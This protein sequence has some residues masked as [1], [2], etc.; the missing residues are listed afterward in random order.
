MLNGIIIRTKFFPLCLLLALS[1]NEED[2]DTSFLVVHHYQQTCEN[3][4][5][6]LCYLIQEDDNGLEPAYD[7]WNMLADITGFEYEL[8]YIYHIEVKK[9]P[10]T[11]PSPGMPAFQYSFVQIH[12][13]TKVDA[14]STFEI[15]LKHANEESFVTKIT[16][17]NFKILNQITIDCKDLCS[18]LSSGIN[19]SN[20]LSGVFVHSDKNTITL[21]KLNTH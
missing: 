7:R 18:E 14:T 9:S 3:Q 15:V 17:T 8:G 10:V 21:T 4:E 12:S 16:D 13:R 19:A 5:K 11:N 2:P 6:H 20:G 1:C